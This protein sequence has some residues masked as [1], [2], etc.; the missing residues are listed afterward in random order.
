M[1]SSFI[2]YRPNGYA[3]TSLSLAQEMDADPSASS[4]TTTTSS[5]LRAPALDGSHYSPVSLELDPTAVNNGSGIPCC[6]PEDTKDPALKTIHSQPSITSVPPTLPPSSWLHHHQK[7]FQSPYIKTS[8]QGDVY[9]FLERPAGLKCFLYHFLVFLMVLVC[10]IFSVLSTIEQYADFATGT[11]FWM[12]SAVIVLIY[13][14]CKTVP[15][16]K[17]LH[18]SSKSSRMNCYI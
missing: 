18:K 13:T 4:G 7:D 5:A 15:T 2:S 3:S 9:N 1:A 11:L 17:G 12:V 16:S 10:L 6:P 8:M 14:K